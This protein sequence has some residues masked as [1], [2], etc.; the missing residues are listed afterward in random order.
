M[1]KCILD[2]LPNRDL[3]LSAFSH[4]TENR[5]W[6]FQIGNFCRRKTFLWDSFY[7]KKNHWYLKPFRET[8]NALCHGY[9]YISLNTVYRRS[10]RLPG[11]QQEWRSAT[12]SSRGVLAG[13]PASSQCPCRNG[14]HLATQHHTLFTASV[15]HQELCGGST[16]ILLSFACKQ[17]VQLYI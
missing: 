13:T 11:W 2:H 9:H 1:F 10:D 8:P 16:L 4:F 7:L 5:T 17:V 14:Q 3:V 12:C 6:T 15:E